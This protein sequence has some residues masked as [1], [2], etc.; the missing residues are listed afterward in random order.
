VN[1]P[2]GN[3]QATKKV[4]IAIMEKSTIPM[5]ANIFSNSLLLPAYNYNLKFLF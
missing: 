2:N 5:I 4:I 1:S 3:P